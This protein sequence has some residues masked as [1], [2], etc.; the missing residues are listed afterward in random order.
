MRRLRWAMVLALAL[1]L[2]A[3]PASAATSLRDDILYLLPRES[4]HVGF[5]DLH[6]L[7]DSPEYETLKQHLLPE[8]FA[9]FERFVGSMGLEVDKDLD[10]L[11]WDLVPAGQHYKQELFL[12]LAEG[13]F[14][15]E[16][17]EQFFTRSKLPMDTY[18][19]QTL[20]PFGSGEAALWF[21]FLDSSTAAFGTRAGLELLLET[22]FGAH[23]NLTQNESF[24]DHLNE[25]NGH[26]PV[27]VVLSDV[28]TRMAVRQLVP[29]AA[30]FDEFQRLANRLH[31]SV[32]QL[33]LGRDLT[34]HFQAWCAQ[35]VDAQT[36]SLL[37]QTA[38][39]SQSWAVEK[40]NPEL[41]GLLRRAQVR[42]AGERLLVNTTIEGKELE[43]LL[44]RG[45][46][47]L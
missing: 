15:P 23:P 25:V 12:G 17:A 20:Y 34:L 31:D 9:H 13:Q 2:G 28:Y 3:V 35:P 6:A 1:A 7:R 26:A 42:T 32:L 45:P 43:A 22:R 33:D 19:G 37:L 18:R 16:M 10:W 4:G 27:W 46:L 5:I 38:L 41:S 44:A 39:L 8:R 29:E 24:L 14:Q 30:K 47:Q 40:D 11:A 21:T 36:F